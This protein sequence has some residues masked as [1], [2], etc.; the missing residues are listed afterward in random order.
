MLAELG[1]PVATAGRPL[2]G[3]GESDCVGMEEEVPMLMAMANGVEWEMTQPLNSETEMVAASE[4]VMNQLPG[5]CVAQT[6]P[7]CTPKTTLATGGTKRCIWVAELSD[8]DENGQILFCNYRARVVFIETETY[9]TINADCSITRC[10]RSRT[11][12]LDGSQVNCQPS[13]TPG[14]VTI[15]PAAPSCYPATPLQAVCNTLSTNPS[16][17]WTAWSKPCP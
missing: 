8:K 1:Y 14:G 9:T 6:A 17:T 7:T 11:G 10:S 16:I 5:P 12:H 15:C 13:T 2:D 3:G 4:S